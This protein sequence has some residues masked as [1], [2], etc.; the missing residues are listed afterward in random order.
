LQLF[1]RFKTV[2]ARTGFITGEFREPQLK[3]V[4]GTPNTEVTVVENGVKYSF[5]CSKLMFAKGNISERVRLAS[6]VH[7]GETIVDMFAGLGYFTLPIAVRAKPKIVYSIELN[8]V[9]FAYLKLNLELNKVERTV[10]AINGD[11]SIEA[12]RLAQEGISADRVLMGYL[13]A[14]KQ[15]VPAALEV[16]KR[17]G[18]LHY[19][20]V[21]DAGSDGKNLFKDV[22]AAAQATGRTAVLEHLQ[23]V[24]SYGPK[25]EHVVLDCRVG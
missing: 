8:P 22:Q 5:D 12:R 23:V 1:P 16:L 24:K 10:Q 4:A 6:L 20:G 19:E 9:A 3:V 21:I 15:H 14:P 7:E 11:C 2:C 17:G 13:P 25:K 18:A